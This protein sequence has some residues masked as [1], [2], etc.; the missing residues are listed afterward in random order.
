ALS[1]R[2]HAEWSTVRVE[3]PAAV[4]IRFCGVCA[5][6]IPLAAITDTSTK[7]VRKLHPHLTLCM[8]FP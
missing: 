6:A 8:I 5:C 1:R 3:L 4:A 7:S 2:S